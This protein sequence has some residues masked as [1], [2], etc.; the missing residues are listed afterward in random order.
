MTWSFSLA[1]LQ[2]NN[3]DQVRVLIGDFN[4]TDPLMQDELITFFMTQRATVYGA[5]AMACQTLAT[6]FAREADTVQDNLHTTYSVRSKSFYA[7]A[8]QY[9]AMAAQ[10]GAGIPYAGGISIAD[11]IQQELNP[12]RVSPQYTIGMDDNYLPVGPAG[13]ETLTG[14]GE[15][16]A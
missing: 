8:A 9:E 7:K 3:K 4:P 11:K 6:Q 5:A 12:D 13:G 2:R 16:P 15:G 14:S 10:R 1:T